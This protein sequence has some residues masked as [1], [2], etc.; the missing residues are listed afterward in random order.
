VFYPLDAIGEWNRV[1]G[2]NGLYQFQCQ[3]PPGVMQAVVAELLGITATSGQASMLSVLKLFGTRVSPGLLSFPAPGATLAMDFP[4][5]G[6]STGGLLRR[7][8]HVVVEAGGRLYPAKDESM[9]AET[10]Q[11]GY[12]GLSRFL[13]HIDPGFSSGFAQRVGLIQRAG[14][15]AY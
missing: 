1:Y 2:P 6:A 4:N 15:Q 10:F 5:R 8:E 7:L 3:I 12:P 11:V 9:R 14:Q 13:P